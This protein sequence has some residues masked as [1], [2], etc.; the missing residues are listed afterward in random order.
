MIQTVTVTVGIAAAEGD[1]VLHVGPV[2]KGGIG[3]DAD[4]AVFVDRVAAAGSDRSTVRAREGI[5]RAIAAGETPPGIRLLAEALAASV[6]ARTAE[7]TARPV[8]P[9]PP[10]DT[11]GP[12]THDPGTRDPGTRDPGIRDA[13][14]EVAAAVGEASLVVLQDFDVPAVAATLAALL[15]DGR[16]IVVTGDRPAELA[17][18]RA[19]VGPAH[20]ERVVDDLRLLPPAEIR[21][22]RGLLATS[23]GARRARAGQRLPPVGLLPPVAEVTRLCRAAARPVA[24]P[25]P[26]IRMITDVLRGLE[27]ARREAVTSVARYVQRS[28]AALP[29]AVDA[30]WIWRLLADLTHQRHRAPFD[31]LREETVQA[32]AALERA[33]ALPLVTVIGPLPG[34]ALATLGRYAEYL[35]GGGGRRA[36]LPM[37]RAM[38]QRD[39]EPIL[40]VLR[41]DGHLP[42]GLGDIGRVIE[43]VELGERLSRIDRACIA[44]GIAAPRDEAELSALT[45]LL[46]RVAAAARAVGALRHDVLFLAEGSPLAVPDL[47]TAGQVAAAILDH[48]EHGADTEATVQLGRLAAALRDAVP[49]AE[50]SREHEDALRALTVRDA[51]AYAVAHHAL[52]SAV[53]AR[54]DEWRLRELLNRLAAVAPRLAAGWEWLARTEPA[55]LGFVC[56]LPVEALLEAPPPPDGVDIVLV[57]EAERSG[58]ERLLLTAVAP[59]LLAVVAP[60]AG[61]E[62]ASTLLGVLRRAGASVISGPVPPQP[63]RPAESLA[64]VVPMPSPRPAPGAV[65]V[66]VPFGQVGT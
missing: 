16:R 23:T 14:A 52:R 64:Q 61:V 41:I 29:S 43:Y 45:H 60:G 26:G 65:V 37:R 54:R 38:P 33:G 31:Q 1:S 35:A 42:D 12:G 13:A 28:L 19:A 66:S 40:R 17:R 4:L 50:R 24:A 36:R 8:P 59:R 55:A 34:D 27:P 49:I 53:R 11:S 30:P 2:A 47:D 20:A 5:R 25:A 44:I 48:A 39:V 9:T 58:I 62:D 10:S 18:L 15:A 21:E 6:I 3:D 51:T 7:G 63:T 46:A 32:A 57:L 22:L 56:L